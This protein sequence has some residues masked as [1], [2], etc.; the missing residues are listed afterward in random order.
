[1][2]N[3]FSIAETDLWER[4]QKMH[5]YRQI[6]SLNFQT[7]FRHRY[8]L[9]APNDFLFFPIIS[10]TAV[11]ILNL[12]GQGGEKTSPWRGG[13]LDKAF[14]RQGFWVYPC[15]FLQVKRDARGPRAAFSGNFS[16]HA[17]LQNA[18]G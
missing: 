15:G 10:A 11:S 3:S 7:H 17:P 9:Q 18:Q 6:L 14:R 16:G 1:M 5:H 4:Q 12:D 13:A 2:Q 8:R